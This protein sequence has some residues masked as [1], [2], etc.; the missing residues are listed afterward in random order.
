MRGTYRF[1]SL[2]ADLPDGEYPEPLPEA[3][4]QAELVLNNMVIPNG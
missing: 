2:F 3:V 1:L 4:T